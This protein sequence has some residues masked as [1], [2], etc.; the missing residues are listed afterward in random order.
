[1]RKQHERASPLDAF[2]HY[3]HHLYDTLSRCRRRRAARA[4]STTPTSV[5][6]RE[7]QYHWG[8][9]ARDVT[10]LKGSQQAANARASNCAR[11]RKRTIVGSRRSRKYK[12]KVQDNFEGCWL[13]WLGLL[14]CRV[15]STLSGEPFLRFFLLPRG[16]QCFAEFSV[17]YIIEFF[18]T[19]S[20]FPDWINKITQ[21]TL[22]I[23]KMVAIIDWFIDF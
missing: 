19:L 11:Q 20:G 5:C 2:A 22:K 18:D 15:L 10:P 14:T 17:S 21:I 9:R 16:T 6:R 8:S 23:L 12:E 13:R 3:C 7:S 1:M 4:T